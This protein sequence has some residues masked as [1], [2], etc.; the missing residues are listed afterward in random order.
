MKFDI[1][2][3]RLRLDNSFTKL[4]NIERLKLIL[5]KIKVKNDW[6]KKIVILPYITMKDYI[7]K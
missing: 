5:I 6:I 4:K 7:D 3:E 1:Y 2:F